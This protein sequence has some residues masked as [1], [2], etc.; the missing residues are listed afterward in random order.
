[1]SAGRCARNDSCHAR[2]LLLAHG[3][4][5]GAASKGASHAKC[6]CRRPRMHLAVLP[7]PRSAREHGAS[8]SRH[9][10]DSLNFRAL[11]G[12]LDEGPRGPPARGTTMI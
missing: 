9:I 12:R 7:R 4:A 3:A 2:L 1:M 8:A 11:G 6:V 10:A 5:A